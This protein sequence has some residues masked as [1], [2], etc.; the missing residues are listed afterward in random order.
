MACLDYSKVVQSIYDASIDPTKWNSCSTSIAKYVNADTAATIFIDHHID[1]SNENPTNL[2]NILST[3]EIDPTKILNEY[4]DYYVSLDPWNTNLKNTTEGIIVSPEEMG[5]DMNT[6][7]HTEYYN[8]FWSKLGLHHPIGGRIELKN[9]TCIFGVHRNKNKGAFDEYEKNKYQSLVPHLRRALNIYSEHLEFNTLIDQ[10]SD[11]ILKSHVGMITLDS[12]CNVIDINQIAE[13]IISRG[14]ALTLQGSKLHALNLK[15]EKFLQFPISDLLDTHSESNQTIHLK[16]P[17]NISSYAINIIPVS[18]GIISLSSSAI[19]Y[20]VFIVDPEIKDNLLIE[21]FIDY[22]NLSR[23]ESK[24]LE[25]LV[26]GHSLKDAA[27][28]LSISKETAR[29]HLK[30]CLLKTF[31]HSQPELVAKVCR[32]CISLDLYN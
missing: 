25:H 26:D 6:F 12:N 16:K 22:Y 10:T 9:A 19:S 24:L 14:D 7:I 3:H 21:N 18:D 29:T 2:K 15:Q 20:Y 8:D 31:T 32:E 13:K 4:A 17:N 28:L 1:S 23:T 5:I 27:D 30:T 11:L